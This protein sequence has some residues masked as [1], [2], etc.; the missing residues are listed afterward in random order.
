MNAPTSLACSKNN[1]PETFYYSFQ[2]RYRGPKA[3]IATESFGSSLSCEYNS[4]AE[5]WAE[6][7]AHRLSYGFTHEYS[8]PD[9][10]VYKLLACDQPQAVVREAVGALFDSL[11]EDTTFNL[12]DFNIRSRE[13]TKQ[14][15]LKMTCGEIFSDSKRDTTARP[16]AERRAVTLQRIEVLAKAAETYKSRRAHFDN[17]WSQISMLFNKGLGKS[18][19]AQEISLTESNIAWVLGDPTA[20]PPK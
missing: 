17:L 7:I 12:V 11:K 18:E 4:L 15:H 16:T 2:V 5:Q 6:E 19:I 3:N 10:S 13:P 1:L 14:N 9:G 8:W 20:D